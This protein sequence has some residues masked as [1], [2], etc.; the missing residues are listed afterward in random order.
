MYKNETSPMQNNN[1]VAIS[2]HA[3]DTNAAVWSGSAQLVINKLSNVITTLELWYGKWKVKKINV[4]KCSTTLF[5]NRLNHFHTEL[6]PL[7]IFYTKLLD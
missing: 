5:S 2:V 1:N 6:R 4:V 3:D 7:K